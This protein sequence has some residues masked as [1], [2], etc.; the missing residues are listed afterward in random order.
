MSTADRVRDNPA[1]SRYELPLEE[2]VAFV[3]YSLRDGL[4]TLLYPEVPR[5]LRGRGVGAEL[6]EGVLKDVRRR[7]LKIVPRC[8]FIASHIIGHPQ[9]RDM[10]A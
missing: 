6:V 1:S 10:L 2:G 4:I 3:D 9:H 7:G 8:P 5:A